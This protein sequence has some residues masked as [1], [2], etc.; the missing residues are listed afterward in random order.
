MPINGPAYTTGKGPY[1]TG[2]SITYKAS[3]LMA[4]GDL[5][6]VDPSDHY[7]HSANILAWS[8]TLLASQIAFK[9]AFQGVSN[10][11]RTVTQTFDGSGSRDGVPFISGEFS[12][13]CATL[14]SSVY[15]ANNQ[16]VAIAQGAGNF[17][18]PV[19]VIATNNISIAIGKLTRNGITGDAQL[20]FEILPATGPFG[21]GPQVIT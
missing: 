4:V 8:G 14:V 11:R 18:N 5:V 6:Y 15:I 7:T 10:V 19:L 17:L 13:P 3:E 21:E 20:T 16:Y 2:G 12:F 1:R 9:A